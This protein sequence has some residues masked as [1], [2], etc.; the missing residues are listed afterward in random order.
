MRQKLQKV[1]KDIRKIW[2]NEPYIIEFLRYLNDAKG[3]NY[4]CNGLFFILKSI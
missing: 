2:C 1:A 3:L 4:V